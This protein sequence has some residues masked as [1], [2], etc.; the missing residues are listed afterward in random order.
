[1][2]H[3]YVP[4]ELLAA[5]ERLDWMV[6]IG[7]TPLSFALAGPVA[8]AVGVEATLIGA[9]CSPLPPSSSSS[10]SRV[11]AI[12]SAGRRARPSPA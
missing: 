8:E 1:M 6:S 12:P 4:T 7:L 5:C 2:I 9:G 10:P 3:R 11:S